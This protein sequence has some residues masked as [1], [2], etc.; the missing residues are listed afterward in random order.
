MRIRT[1]HVL[2]P[3]LTDIGDNGI[4]RPLRG[5]VVFYAPWGAKLKKESAKDEWQME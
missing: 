4:I 3:F 2:E 5:G 1:G